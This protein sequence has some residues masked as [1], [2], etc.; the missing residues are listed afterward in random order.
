MF[1][2]ADH[3]TQMNVQGAHENVIKTNSQLVAVMQAFNFL[4]FCFVLS[5]GPLSLIP[6]ILQIHGFLFF[7]CDWLTHTCALMH[8]HTHTERERERERE[9]FINTA[10]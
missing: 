3:V 4:W 10:H 8:K 5:T 6:L 2:S 9:R 7:N 1:S